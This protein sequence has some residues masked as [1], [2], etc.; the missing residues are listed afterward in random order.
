MKLLHL[1]FKRRS[2]GIPPGT[3]LTGNGDERKTAFFRID[4][5]TVL[6]MIVKTVDK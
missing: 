6:L 1:L 5:R 4:L 3:G 2:K